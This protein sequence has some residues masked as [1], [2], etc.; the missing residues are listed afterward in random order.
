[1]AVLCWEG[2]F[3]LPQK[4]PFPEALEGNLFAK[5]CCHFD[6]LSDRVVAQGEC[7]AEIYWHFDWL[8]DRGGRRV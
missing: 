5:M 2:G 7:L 3:F 8:S 6:K 4:N 1:M